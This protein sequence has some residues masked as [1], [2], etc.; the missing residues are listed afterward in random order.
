MADPVTSKGRL[1]LKVLTPNHVGRRLVPL[2]MMVVML[3]GSASGLRMASA[4]GQPFPG[5]ASMWRKELSVFTVSYVTPPFASGLAAGMRVNDRLLCVDGFLLPMDATT[6]NR[7]AQSLQEHC[8]Q[9]DARYPQVFAQRSVANNLSAVSFVVERRG[10]LFTVDNVPVR[11][12]DP[13]TLAELFLPFFLLGL[14][15]LAIAGVTYRAAPHEQVNLIF[16]ALTTAMAGFMLDQFSALRLSPLFPD[17]WPVSLILQGVWLPFIGVLI[18]HLVALMTTPG[19]LGRT[20]HRGLHLAYAAAAAVASLIVLTYVVR[21][22]A[23]TRPTTWFCL[24]F[25]TA[26]SILALAWGFLR[27][28]HV[29]RSSPSPRAQRQARLMVLGMGTVFATIVPLYLYYLTDIPFYRF[30]QS[31]PYLGLGGVALIAY[32]ILRYQLF[33]S[34]SRI[35]TILVVT[36]LCVLAANLIYLVIGQSVSFLPIL[37]AAAVTGG[38]LSTRRGP[39]AMLDRLLRREM[40]DYDTVAR[41]SQQVGALPGIDAILSAIDDCLR[42]DLDAERVR[43]WL[44]DPERLTLECFEDGQPV[45]EALPDPRLPETLIAHPDPAHSPSAEAAGLADLLGDT[46]ETIAVW[47][48][49]VDRDQAVGVLGLGA[50]WTGEVYDEQ[51]M[52]LLAILARQ[53][54]LAILNTRQIERLRATAKLIQQAEENERRK[55]ARELHDTILQFLL[56][57]TYGLDDLKER[58]TALT[59]EIERWQERISAEAGQLRSLLSYLRAPE[60]LVQQG[61]VPSLASWL[62]Q[63]QQETTMAI[64]TDLAPEV[65]PLLNTEAKVAIYRVCREAVHNAIKHSGGSR[66]VVKIWRDSQAVHFSV[67][68][69]GCSFDVDAALAGGEKGYSS[70]QDL[71]IYVESVGGRLEVESEWKGGTV[72]D[73]WAPFYDR[74]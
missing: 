44:W 54:A 21:N 14:G 5:F 45:G 1:W 55:I 52:R 72:I 2:A 71:R 36:A 3:G 8:R 53:T 47:A 37:A 69:D 12:F 6:A 35:L 22:E 7:H 43:V 27:L 61:L 26:G 15:F 56:V 57:L 64:E 60:L 23:L 49:L 62:A 65:E 67:E 41:F 48:P 10:R 39:A 32:A 70:L 33:G 42:R 73:A 58:Q 34:K 28:G 30:I 13:V 40:L 16:A 50:R 19:G 11:R 63:V 38:V 51:D 25:C 46:G 4:L 59:S 9:G 31:L 74:P 24:L 68:D 20:A 29:N 66:V 18:A 17:F